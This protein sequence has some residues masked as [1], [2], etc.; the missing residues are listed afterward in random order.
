MI[1]GHDGN[2]KLSELA[3]A[4]SH[5]SAAYKRTRTV[6]SGAY[7]NTRIGKYYEKGAKNERHFI[8]KSS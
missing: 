7:S 6:Y 8:R 1:K 3:V 2:E 5:K 4:Q